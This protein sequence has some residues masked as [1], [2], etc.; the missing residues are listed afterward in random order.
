ML[1]LGAIALD[2]LFGG[3]KALGAIP[4]FDNLT[5]VLFSILRQRLERKG[6]G[7]K[8]LFWRGGLV[9]VVLTGLFYAAGAM[10]DRL[11][12]AQAAATAL[13][14]AVLARYLQLKILFQSLNKMAGQQA[15]ASRRKAIE[16]AL[17]YFCSYYCPAL[18]LFLIGGFSLLIPFYLLHSA[19]VQQKTDNRSAYLKPFMIA[20]NLT[21]LPGE[22]LSALFLLFGTTLWPATHMLQ[23]VKGLLVCG[24]TPKQWGPSIM[25]HAFGISLQSSWSGRPKW[26]G[27][28]IGSADIDTITSRNA[29]IVA[30]VAFATSLAFLLVLLAGA[31]LG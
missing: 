7:R 27:S 10:L 13:S 23:G 11:V 3:R 5:E 29:L 21:A 16:Q 26:L 1:W 28:D 15:S 20:R 12:F 24:R 4:S 18:V 6:R 2:A 31:L 19:A 17:H 8:A 25:A 9:L 14:M 30:L 22:C